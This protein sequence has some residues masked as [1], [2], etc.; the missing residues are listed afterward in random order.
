MQRTVRWAI[1]LSLG[2][3]ACGSDVEVAAELGHSQLALTDVDPDDLVAGHGMGG[4]VFGRGEVMGT[5]AGGGGF[6]RPS[7]QG[8]VVGGGG[9]GKETLA[10]VGAGGG[11]FG[12]SQLD[13]TGGG[14]STPPALEVNVT[15]G[16]SG[17]TGIGG[18]AAQAAAGDQTQVQSGSNT[19]FA[20]PSDGL[21]L[22]DPRGAVVAA[23]LT[24]EALSGSTSVWFEPASDLTLVGRYRVTNRTGVTQAAVL[25]DATAL[26]RVNADGEIEVLLP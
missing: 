16:M 3:G 18:G 20:V 4:G 17:G 22:R 9:F 19:V 1:W 7:V 13:G 24:V 14:T 2:L 10:G 26:E 23:E 5:G 6:G 21:E 11:N 12:R 15:G 8:V 25:L